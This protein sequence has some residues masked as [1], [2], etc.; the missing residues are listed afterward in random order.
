MSVED[1]GPHEPLDEGHRLLHSLHVQ[2]M[3]MV[4]F[5]QNAIPLPQFLSRLYN[6]LSSEIWN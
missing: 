4:I 1:G 6:K 5:L 2:A 3:K